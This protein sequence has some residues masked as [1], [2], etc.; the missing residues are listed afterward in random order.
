MWLMPLDLQSIVVMWATRLIVQTMVSMVA[1]N[2]FALVA[3]RATDDLAWS[4]TWNVN[5]KLLPMPK[6]YLA[7]YSNYCNR[8]CH[9]VEVVTMGGLVC[10]LL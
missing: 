3:D 1:T 9:L 8:N 4:V 6:Y 10:A 5:W 7:N 2:L